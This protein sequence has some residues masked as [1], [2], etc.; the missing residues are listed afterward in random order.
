MTKKSLGRQQRDSELKDA[1]TEV[2]LQ[3]QGNKIYDDI[4][5][6]YEKCA[7]TLVGYAHGFN[8]LCVDGA[9]P[10]MTPEQRSKVQTLTSGFIHDTKQ[11]TE[12]LV[13]INEPFK[14]KRGGELNVN[15]FVD[16]VGVVDQ[17][18][19]FI[20]RCKGVLDPTFRAMAAEIS[21]V[22]ARLTANAP[23]STDVNTKDENAN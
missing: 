13:K 11:F 6:V 21:E 9:L 19:E 2:S 3:I 4:Q 20:G 22:E 12:D 5:E 18:S 16:T 8:E 15:K 1:R 17:F 14:D 7:H 23:I 10:Y